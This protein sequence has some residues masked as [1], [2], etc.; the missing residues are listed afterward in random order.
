MLTRARATLQSPYGMIESAWRIEADRFHL[1]IVIPPNT[2][3]TV[4]LPFSVGEQEVAAGRHSFQS[5]VRS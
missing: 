5:A 4:R 2:T 1:D 3:A